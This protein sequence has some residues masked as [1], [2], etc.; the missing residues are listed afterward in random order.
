MRI[1]KMGETP[2]YVGSV[3]FDNESPLWQPDAELNL[4]FLHATINHLV[5]L[6]RM[7]GHL[8]LNEVFDALSL[9]RT[10]AGAT[11]GWW[12]T[13]VSINVCRSV[14]PTEPWLDVRVERDIHKKLT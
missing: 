2:T 12:D 11:A 4:M 14:R 8:F 7:R 10:F 5:E 3:L 13:E 1:I 6:K 9:P